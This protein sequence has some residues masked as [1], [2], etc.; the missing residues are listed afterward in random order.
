[1]K[2]SLLIMTV[3]ALLS[4]CQTEGEFSTWPCRFGYDNGL[5][6]DATLASAMEPNSRGVFCKIWESASAGVVFLNFQN[7]HG[8]TSSKEETAMERQASYVLGLNNGIIVGFP[9]LGEG[10]AAYDAQCP[11]CVRAS[12]NY[13]NPKYPVSM[14]STGIATCQKCNRKYDL[15]NGGI[16]QNGEQG[17]RGLEKYLA[18]T[19]GPQGYISAGTKR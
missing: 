2:W 11:N 4:G 18:S 1:M 5:H 14:S 15:N 13:V 7:N 12:D 17:D 3:M 10:F 9:T 6:L 8:M 16:I 19:T